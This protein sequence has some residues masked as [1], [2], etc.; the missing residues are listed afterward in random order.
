MYSNWYIGGVADALSVFPDVDYKRIGA[1]GICG[2]GG[3][4]LRASQ[5]ETDKRFKVVATLLSV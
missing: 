4:K 1:F 3:Y 2:G 5:T